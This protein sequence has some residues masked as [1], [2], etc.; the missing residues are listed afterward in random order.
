MWLLNIKKR[1]IVCQISKWCVVIGGNVKEGSTD[2]ES[3]IDVYRNISV[4]LKEEN[5]EKEKKIGS[6]KKFKDK[7][8]GH[9]SVYSYSSKIYFMSNFIQMQK[10]STTF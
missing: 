6:K 3:I 7:T 5:I 2:A 4:E 8:V 9:Q 10:M 1:F